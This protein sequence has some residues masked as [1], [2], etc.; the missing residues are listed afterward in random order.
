MNNRSIGHEYERAVRSYINSDSKLKA[1]K[2]TN[3]KVVGWSGEQ[4]EVDAIIYKQNEPIA[5]VEVKYHSAGADRR[6][7]ENSM[8]RAIA[9]LVD[10]RYSKLPGAVIVPRRR[11]SPQQSYDARLGA[12]GCILVESGYIN[13]GHDPHQDIK[14]FLDSIQDFPTE[15]QP[16]VLEEYFDNIT[17]GGLYD[18]LF[19]SEKH[20]ELGNQE[21][22]SDS[23]NRIAE[24]YFGD[25]P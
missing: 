12:I 10:L 24:K 22:A 20:S 25:N 2:T 21:P 19:F 15:S 7:F 23:L 8:K 4:Y 18:G 3:R 16:K 13:N 14:D 1:Y 11:K 17:V 9:Q 6:S 5:Y